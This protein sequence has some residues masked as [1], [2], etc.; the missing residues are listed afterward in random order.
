[1]SN[2]NFLHNL[3]FVIKKNILFVITHMKY[4]FNTNNNKTI[5]IQ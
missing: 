5:N 4:F 3:V 1:M 2:C